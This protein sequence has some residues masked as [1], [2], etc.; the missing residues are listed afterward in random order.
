[1]IAAQSAIIRAAPLHWSV[2]NI[3]HLWRLDKNL[4]TPLVVIHV[5]RYQHLFTAVLWA[6]L[7]HKNFVVLENNLAFN[8]IQASRADGNYNVV[9]KVGSNALCQA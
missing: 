5:V 4:A 9:E 8:L 7:Q 3:W 6:A 2:V 1:M